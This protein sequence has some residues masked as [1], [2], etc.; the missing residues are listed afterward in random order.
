MKLVLLTILIALQL[1]FTGCTPCCN[2]EDFCMDILQCGT[3]EATTE[4]D[5]AAKGI[6]DIHCEEMTMI[7]Q[8]VAVEL[9]YD[10]RLR[11][12]D[13]K[14]FFND[15]IHTIQINFTS[16]D[17]KDMCEAREL[18]VDVTEKLLAKLNQDIILGPE[19]SNFPL[20]PENLEIYITFES[21]YGRYVDPYYVAWIGLEDGIV[22]YETFSLKDNNK[23]CWSARRE[24]YCTSREIVVYERQAEKKY[25]DNNREKRDIFGGRRFYPE[26]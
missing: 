13:A 8:E 25:R 6:P 20:R 23:D 9:K 17:L 24:S 26:P 1:A 2:Q 14:T 15:G 19:Y 18:I 4:E 22:L 7:V 16:Q 11:L 5:L 10:K 3:K 12:E 21:Y